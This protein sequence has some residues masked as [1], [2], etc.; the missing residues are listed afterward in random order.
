MNKFSLYK[1]K[2]LLYI[3]QKNEH[4]IEYYWC[5]MSTTRNDHRYYI[6]EKIKKTRLFIEQLEEYIN[7]RNTNTQLTLF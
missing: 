5:I 1:T 2:D 4:L 7:K 3:I 6:A